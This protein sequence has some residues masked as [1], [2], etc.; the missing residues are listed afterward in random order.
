MSVSP[1]VHGPHR[2]ADLL[3]REVHVLDPRSDLDAPRDLLVRDGH[4]AELAEPGTLTAPTGIETL[5]GRGRHL[6]PAFF[7]PHVHLRSPGQEHKEDI[8]TGTRAAAAGGFC[9]V[10]AMPNTDPVIDSPPLLRSVREEAAQRARVP[11]GFLGAIT[12][13]LE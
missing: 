5:S 6:L 3:L 9:A 13:G 12:H 1:L 11:V 10:I 2:P 4:I 7:D 8:E